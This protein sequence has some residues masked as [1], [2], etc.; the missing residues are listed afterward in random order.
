MVR[1]LADPQATRVNGSF[2][3]RVARLCSVAV[4]VI[5]DLGSDPLSSQAAT[6]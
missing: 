5:D 3:R 4:L 2:A 6:R 1:D